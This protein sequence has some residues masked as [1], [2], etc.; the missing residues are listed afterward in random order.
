M[1][2][3]PRA[4]AE[5]V[6]VFGPVSGAATGVAPAATGPLVAGAVAVSVALVVSVPVV[7][8]PTVDDELGATDTDPA[9]FASPDRVDVEL[10]VAAEL[11]GAA[12]GAAAGATDTDPAVFAS[13]DRVDVFPVWLVPVPV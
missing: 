5:S 2:V 11:D 7:S 10:S 13:P 1:F 6:P 12:V 3:V 8:D 9:V 4:G